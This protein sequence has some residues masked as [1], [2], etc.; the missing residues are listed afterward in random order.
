[1]HPSTRVVLVHGSPADASSWDRVREISGE[2]AG[3]EWVA[4]DRLGYGNSTHACET[5]LCAQARSLEPLLVDPPEHGVILVGHSF[6]GPVVLRAAVEFPERIAGIVLVAGAC[7][8]NMKDSQWFRK[9]VEALGVA[10]PESWSHANRELLALTDEN[11]AMEP[12][13]DRVRCPVVVIHGT[14]D[15]VCPFEGTAAY[16]RSHLTG[17]SEL[18]IVEVDRALHNLHISHA[19]TV[20]H[21]VLRLI[22][23]S[24]LASR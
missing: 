17:A 19:D 4:V 7:D 11:R 9:G 18:R 5:S 10:V 2:V 14:W 23:D 12:L 21:E 24:S 13:L 8:A 22:D 16:L 3:V 1:M 6:G 20:M 15:P